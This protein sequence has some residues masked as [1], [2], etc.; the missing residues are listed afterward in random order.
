MTADTARRRPSTASRRVG[1]GVSAAINIVALYL[2]NVWP[3]WDA[4]P[5][6][7]EQTTDVIPLVNAS[8]L[9]GVI[10]SLAQLVH[11][12][13]WLVAL[14][15]MTTTAIGTL[16]LIRMWQVFPFDFGGTSFDWPLATRVFLAVCIVGS[17]AGFA[18]QAVALVGALREDSDRT[19]RL[20]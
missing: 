9:A 16:S 13:Q 7:T 6:L 8:L 19:R 10:V 18:V 15:S 12:P 20:T 11:D 14:G 1:Y 4:A 17:I 3:G 5:F 2:V